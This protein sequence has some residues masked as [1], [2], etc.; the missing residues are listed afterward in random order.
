[1]LTLHVL[2]IQASS[3]IVNVHTSISTLCNC[4][5]VYNCVDREGINLPATYTLCH[6]KLLA[7]QLVYLLNGKK[8]E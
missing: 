7:M 4:I 6:N 8:N 3:C 2:T 5:Q 1:M